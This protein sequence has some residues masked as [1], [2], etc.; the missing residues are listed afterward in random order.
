MG[1]GRSRTPPESDDSAQA[2]LHG[3]PAQGG[4]SGRGPSGLGGLHRHRLAAKTIHRRA[5]P[6]RWAVRW[7]LN[8]HARYAMPNLPLE[9]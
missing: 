8:S 7:Q 3:K 2:K 9:T 5:D 6:A 1:Q 4:V